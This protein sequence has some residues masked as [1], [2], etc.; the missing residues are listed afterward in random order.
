MDQKCSLHQLPPLAQQ[1]AD[2]SNLEVLLNNQ[3]TR[4][5]RVVSQ[6]SHIKD[7]LMLYEVPEVKAEHLAAIL[8]AGNK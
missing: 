2:A 7:E 8:T 3:K 5:A 4:A 1:Q 6:W